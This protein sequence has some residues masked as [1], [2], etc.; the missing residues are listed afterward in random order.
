MIIIVYKQ[1][2][3]EKKEKVRE[4]LKR[5]KVLWI[6]QEELPVFEENGRIVLE[7]S[8]KIMLESKGFGGII[9]SFISINF[10]SYFKVAIM[11]PQF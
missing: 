5:K 2:E 1:N 7:N 4:Q 6:V 11:S 8:K 9:R 3:E 10:Y